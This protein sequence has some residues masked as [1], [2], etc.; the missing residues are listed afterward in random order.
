MTLTNGD[1]KALYE[2]SQCKLS[3][4]KK[5]V[6]KKAIQLITNQDIM[7]EP[8]D[9]LSKKKSETEYHKQV[10]IEYRI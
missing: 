6:Q 4:Q 1:N 7:K 9:D 8:Y 3:N 2:E 10:N 5:N